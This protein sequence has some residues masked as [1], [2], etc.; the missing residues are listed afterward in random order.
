MGTLHTRVRIN[1]FMCVYVH[2]SLHCIVY[3]GMKVKYILEISQLKYILKISQLKYILKISQLKYNL[4]ISQ[5]KYI[6]KI[7]QL[8]Y[9]LKISQQDVSFLF[10]Y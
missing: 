6:L 3:K 1:P 7:S 4:K 10:T 8:K 5:L 2:P 9:I